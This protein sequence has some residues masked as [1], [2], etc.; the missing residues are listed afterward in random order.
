MD[1]TEPSRGVAPPPAVGPTAP[2]LLTPAEIAQHVARLGREIASDHPD[3]VVVVA[4][5]KGALLFLA[6][7]VRALPID[8]TVDFM[9]ISRFAPH[10]GRVR[11]LHDVATDITGRDV[12][13]VE[14]IVDTGLT[15]SYLLRQL[16]TRAP[17]RLSACALL[18]RP[19]RRIVPLDLQYRGI[20]LDDEYV[21]GYG[22]HVHDLYRNLP[23]VVK[24]D[25]SVLAVAPDTYLEALYGDRNEPT[26][27]VVG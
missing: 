16:E 7:L 22:L 18:D 10:S 11:I 27:P 5:L 9:A 24:A 3:G 25:P 20:A 1:A 2:T 19:D 8:T 17:R 13:V 21:L 14:D 12:V 23:G 26:T 15:L 4:V 6:D